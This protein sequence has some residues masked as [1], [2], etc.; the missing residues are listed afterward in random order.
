M[1]QDMFMSSAMLARCRELASPTTTPAR[2]QELLEQLDGEGHRFFAYARQRDQA[3]R[4]CDSL[5]PRSR[6]G[7]AQR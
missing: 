3:R 5:R 4:R 6:A 1:D 7:L 2:R